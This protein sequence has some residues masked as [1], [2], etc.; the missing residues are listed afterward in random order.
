MVRRGSSEGSL[1]RRRVRAPH[2]ADPLQGDASDCS[3][4][5]IRRPL[6]D[7]DLQSALAVDV[8]GPRHEEE[9]GWT[10]VALLEGGQT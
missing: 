7:A 4:P 1:F 2:V 5:E 6:P 8:S 10:F 9:S 3:R